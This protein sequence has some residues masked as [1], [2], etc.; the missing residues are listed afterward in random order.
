MSHPHEA[1][2][3]ANVSARTMGLALAITAVILAVEV[4]GGLISHSLA[5]LSDAGHMLVDVLAL[6]ISLWA[7]VVARRPSTATRTYGFHRAEIMAALANGTVL[8]VVA[9]L[10]FH[11]AYQRLTAEAPEV[12]APIMLVVAA[13]GL[14]ANAVEIYLLRRATR[15]TLNVKAAFWHI[16]G[17]TISSIGVIVGGLIIMFTN[18]TVVDPI[19]A[20][21]IGVIILW[22]AVRLVRDSVE[23]L[24]ESVPK[25]IPIKSVAE[26]LK[27]VPGVEDVHDLHV[28]TITSGI[29][30]LS[31]HLMIEDQ[32]ISR[33][34][35]VVDAAN[36]DLAE[37]FDIRH[38]TLQLEC[39]KCESCPSGIVCN[40]SRPEHWQGEAPD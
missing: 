12:E 6:A 22:G 34:T 38:T 39:N 13:I 14:V 7:I 30:A 23:V 37:R 4:V 24:M 20:A 27:N 25:N 40:I 26:A 10:I 29:V 2:H 17:D 11:E 33:S 19:M 5:L 28:W 35:E 16:L 3:V 32:M 1:E 18:Q 15:G 8:V 36:R 21:V 31:A 9:L